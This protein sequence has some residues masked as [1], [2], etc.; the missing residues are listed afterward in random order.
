LQ[1]PWVLVLGVSAI[2]PGFMAAALLPF[3]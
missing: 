3:R 2:G 1:R